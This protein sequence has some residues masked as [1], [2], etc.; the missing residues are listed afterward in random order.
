M[1]E[2]TIRKAI[3]TDAPA[4]AAFHVRIWRETYRDIAPQAAYDQL[5]E[6][7]R[8][9]GWHKLLSTKF[10]QSGA[11]L[12]EHSGQISGLISFA[13]A[14][15]SMPEGHIEITHLYVCD[16]QRGQGLGR[17]MMHHVFDHLAP[18]LGISL[19][20]VTQN[21]AARS[22]YIRM[23]GVEAATFVDPGPL[24]RS[25]NIRVDWPKGQGIIS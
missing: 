14:P 25:D 23:G 10:S 9:P 15:P 11:F 18:H 22:F 19:A 21:T 5:D 20:V 16:S 2:H 7:R 12:A 8:L 1:P 24:W 6:T 4:L 13:P 3:Q 17:R